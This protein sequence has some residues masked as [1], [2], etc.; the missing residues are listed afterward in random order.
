MIG[1]GCMKNR[2]LEQFDRIIK[3]R[4]EGSNIHNYLKRVMKEQINIIKLIPISRR[5]V[6]VILRYSDYLKL[7]QYRSVYKITVVQ[8]MGKLKL[9]EDFHRNF[10]LL[11]C[12]V[13]GVLLIFFLSRVI[14]QVE[15][16]HQDKEIRD[17]VMSELDKYDVKKY[18][19][20]KSYDRLEEIEDKIL[21]GNKDKLEWIEIVEYG[22]KYSVRVEER[23]LNEEEEEFQYQSIVSKK[24]AVIVEVDAIRGEKVKNVHDYVKAGDTVIAGYI[25]LPNNTMVKTMAEGKVYG[26]VWYRID[27]D[28]PFV[29][30]ESNLTGKSKTV[31]VLHFFGKRISLFD[32][33]K[34]RSFQSRDKVIFS[35]D[36]PSISF[37][38][39]KQY[40]LEVKDEVYTEDMVESKAI[41]YIR[42][43]M[44][45]DNKDIIDIQE[46]K[47]L[48]SVI[49]EDSIRF[50]LFV[51]AIEDIGKVEK[52]LE[53]DVE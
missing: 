7:I 6:Y 40:E 25:T 33:D 52:I 31:Y 5:E 46:V 32:F 11:C 15:V 50:K 34:Y 37:V 45:D 22:T 42:Q 3:I 16:I 4:I 10:V 23:K 49:D 27:A 12:L 17:L 1:E 41:Q 43:K 47:I 13:L 24:N 29:Y 21:E 44:M 51:R 38:K 35:S 9:R 18:T 26:E 14:F 2:Y 39:E 28:Y 48:S 30:Q 8:K 53:E 20:K 19:F 36:I